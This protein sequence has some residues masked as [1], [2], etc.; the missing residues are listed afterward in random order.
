MHKDSDLSVEFKE[1]YGRLE[2]EMQTSKEYFF[3]KLRNITSK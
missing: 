1:A 3:K 2:A